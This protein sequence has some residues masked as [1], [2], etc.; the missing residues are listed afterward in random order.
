MT[1]S[2]QQTICTRPFEWFEIHPDGSVFLCCPAWLKRPAGN[3]L[4]QSVAEIWNGP[5]ARELRKSIL[6]GSFHNCSRRRCPHRAGR[7]VPVQR[8]AT[9]VDNTVQAAISQ[10]LSC[11]DYPPRHLNLCFEQSCN[12]A[13][14]SCRTGRHQVTGQERLQAERIRAIVETEL[15]PQAAGLTLSGFGDPFASRSYYGLLTQLNPQTFP[16]LQSLRLHTNGLLFSAVAWSAL[17]GLHSLLREV[18]ISLDAASEQTYRHNRPGGNFR[19]LLENLAFLQELP[20]KRTLSMVVQRNNWREIPQLLQ[21]AGRF[22]A[23]IYLSRLVNW[24]TFTREE[25][26]KRAV[27]RPEHPEHRELVGLLLSLAQRQGIELGNLRALIESAE[28]KKSG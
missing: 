20:I 22:N 18:E 4:R 21:L 6:N 11:L 16:K 8:L 7:S 25:Y 26:L 13:C 24:G 3:L 12:L 15:L 27:H 9:V 28:G 10:N 5:L 2:E 17:P 14:P 19:Q 1:L 23:G